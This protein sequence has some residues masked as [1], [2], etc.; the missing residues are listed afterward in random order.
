MK[1]RIVLILPFLFMLFGCDTKSEP[2]LER[3][4]VRNESDY[5]IRVLWTSASDPD[6]YK[7]R[8]VDSDGG[9]GYNHYFEI[10]GIIEVLDNN[11][12]VCIPDD[13]PASA[14]VFP[15]LFYVDSVTKDFCNSWYCKI[16]TVKNNPRYKNKAYKYSIENKYS[17]EISMFYTVYDIEGSYTVPAASESAKIVNFTFLYEEPEFIFRMGDRIIDYK[18]VVQETEFENSIYIT[19]EE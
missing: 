8:E 12:G 2:E 15:K 13:D 4:C 18:K 11:R 14:V 3:I 10:T 19:L 5:T 17:S 7:I 6:D 1:G 16:Y 9:K